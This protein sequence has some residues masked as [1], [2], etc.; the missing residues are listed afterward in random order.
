MIESDKI[1]IILYLAK[2]MMNPIKIRAFF[3]FSLFRGI[4]GYFIMTD[5]VSDADYRIGT[6]RFDDFVRGDM[7]LCEGF[8]D[9]FKP[10]N[11]ISSFT[12]T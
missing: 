6:N 9:G 5:T 7:T 11:S 8:A 3:P 12:F 10:M 1:L 2:K 4:F